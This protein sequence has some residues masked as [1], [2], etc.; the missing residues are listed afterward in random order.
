MRSSV[1]LRFRLALAVSFLTAVVPTLMA[2]SAG[3]GALTGTVTDPSSSV[4]P[5]VSVTLTSV[6]TAQVRVTTT[7]P[8]GTYKFALLPPGT[9]RVRFAASGFKTTE[10]P[11]VI[12]NVTETP[13][14]DRGLEV[15][16][17]AEQV[18]VE[19]T[20][21]TIQTA[22]S[23]LGTVVGERAVIALPLTNRNYTQILSMSAD[24][25]VSVN[26]ASALGRGSQDVSVNGANVNQNNYQMDGVNVDNFAGNGLAGDAGIYA[27]I[28]I[29]NPDA[30][31]EFKIQTSTYDASYGR[32]PGANVNVVTKS[33]SNAIHGSLFE[34]FRN[35]A[36]N[37][38]D[39]FRNRYCG[40]NA[41][42][43]AA[44]GGAKQVLNQNQYGGTIGMPLKKD[45]LF[46]FFSYQGTKQV[47]GVGTQGYSA[48]TLVPLPA[49]D[50]S[51]T[52]AFQ[53]ALG[54]LW[55][56]D[57]HPGD[58]RY[59][60]N[61]AVG[62]IQVACDGS[63]INPV[64]IKFLQLK[65]PNG[66]YYVPGSTNGTFQLTPFSQPAH[67]T[68]NQAVANVDYVFNSKHTLGARFF[69]SQDPQTIPFTNAN[70]ELPGTP[71]SVLYANTNAVLKLTSVLSSAF[72]NEG[73]IS[74]Q[75]NLA[76]EHNGVPFTATQLG[77]TPINPAIDVM[78]PITISGAFNMAGGIGDD[79]FDPTDQFQ[80]AD[81][82]SWSHG[83]HTIRAGFEIEHV[84][85]D[86]VFKGIER[87]NTTIQDFPDFLIGR[88]ACAPGD[89]TCSVAN[90]GTSNGSVTS[91]NIASCLFCVRSGPDGIIHGYRTNN[92]NAFVQDDFKV[93]QR[94]TLNLGVRWEYDGT[95]SDKYG[96]LTNVWQSQVLTVPVP[97]NSPA[98]GSLAGYV[99]P[100]NFQGTVPSGVLKANRDLPVKS[101]PPMD[102]FGPRFGFAWQPFGSGRFVV[103]GGVGM[104]YDRIG[105]NLFVHSVE[106]GNPYAVTLD[107]AGSANQPSSLQQL[108]P[109]TPLSFVPRWVNFATG[110]NSN[111]NLPFITES[112]HTPLVRQYNLN[113]QY[114]FVPK[115]VLELGFVGSS[116]I[117]L[118]DYNHNYNAALLASPTNP[119]NG[120]TTNTVANANL[121][122]PYLGFAAS[123]F[124]GTGFDGIS[125]YNSLQAT[126]RKTLSHGVTLQASYTWSKALTD[127]V[128]FG[129][130]Y[131]YPNSLSQQYGQAYFN[132]P[133]RFV[134]N[135]SWD[136]PFGHPAGFL[137]KLAEGWNA[138]GVTVV[139]DGTPLTF[140]DSRSGSIYGVS[141]PS[142]TSPT[143]TTVTFGT[144]NV[145]RAQLCPGTTSYN[146]VLTSGGV[147]SRLGGASGGAGYFNASSFCAPP[148]IGNGFDY[149]N[150][151]VGV[152]L[153]P[154]QFN[155]DLS[156]NKTTRVGGIREDGTLQFRAEFFNAFNHPQ[157]NNPSAA[158]TTASTFGVI[159]QTSVSPR[160]IQ[161]AL[162]YTF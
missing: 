3:T 98:T 58:S 138:S 114:E 38:N 71:A 41:A 33:G 7:G 96:N 51:N 36:L 91:S 40:A 126:V 152:V 42:I 112:I 77:M 60:T 76:A 53:N 86:I 35:T 11:S 55:C 132:R 153:G 52:A 59:K 16:S 158:V 146:S 9:Y 104:F 162:K 107:F 75:R 6:D 129:A 106:Q 23:T 133:Q 78:N 82:V 80:I 72:V 92:I 161:F 93:S 113:V 47:N 139:Q 81:T 136:L 108:F 117:N 73:R 29:P 46:F 88:A 145:G 15:G 37:A 123:G 142:P 13:V 119:I 95:L 89:S 57:N 135:Y 155:W 156:I 62:G 49:G 131:G 65:L 147:E 4:I 154:P 39:F 5:N 28:G 99:V 34:F 63:N 18:T 67:F 141:G 48:P 148:A 2:Q 124:Q 160:L 90:P 56:P 43:C 26:N 125:N 101:G 79:V 69:T 121:R 127:L 14:L 84:N 111:L 44:G 130:N 32:N 109:N 22:S 19:A 21:E 118:V 50:R 87:G 134:F 144:V 20:S 64:A 110:A 140:T 30:L 159:T 68:E 97:G 10:V 150:S 151:A 149:G 54:Q 27:G 1:C 102:N 100:S 31:Q 143:L 137:G 83:R 45:K 24:A 85:W 116:G 128:G 17:Q 122:V 74:F 105:G 61:A 103:R 94:L 70:G 8:D 12:I 25:N 115:W 157:F 66:S 120:I